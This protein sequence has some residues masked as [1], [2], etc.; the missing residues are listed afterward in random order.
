MMSVNED[1]NLHSTFCQ[2]ASESCVASPCF[3]NKHFETAPEKRKKSENIIL[4][5]REQCKEL[6][7]PHLSSC[8]KYGN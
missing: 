5:V 1:C 2:A 3:S 6:E 7:L 4:S 8:R